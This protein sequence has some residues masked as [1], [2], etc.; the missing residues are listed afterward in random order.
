MTDVSVSGERERCANPL[1]TSGGDRCIGHI[2]RHSALTTESTDASA[3][4][5]LGGD[6]R[7]V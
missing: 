2:A 6:L 1:L 4:I 7:G 5:D 3:A